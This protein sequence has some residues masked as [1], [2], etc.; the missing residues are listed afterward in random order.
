MDTSSNNALQINFYAVLSLD[1]EGMVKM[2]KTL[3]SYGLRGTNQAEAGG[4]ATPRAQ[5]RYGSDRMC[6]EVAR[7]MSGS[8]QASRRRGT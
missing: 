3:Y 6:Q 1:D 8:C 5:K 4:N 2:F 7:T